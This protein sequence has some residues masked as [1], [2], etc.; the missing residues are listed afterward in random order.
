[1]DVTDFLPA[2]LLEGSIRTKYLR[3]EMD[4]LGMDP[5]KGRVVSID[6]LRKKLPR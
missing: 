1:M 5:T 2:G 6:C 3:L 4:T